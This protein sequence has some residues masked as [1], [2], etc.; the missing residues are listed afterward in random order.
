MKTIQ[1]NKWVFAG[2]LALL[3]MMTQVVSGNPYY[4]TDGDSNPRL[5]SIVSWSLDPDTLDA[6]PASPG[7]G[8]DLIFNRNPLNTE[9]LYAHMGGTDRHYNSFTFRS[10]GTTDILRSAIGN[11]SATSDSLLIVGSGG[12]ILE[13]GAGTVNFGGTGQRVFMRADGS[14]SIVNNSSSDLTFHWQYRPHTTVPAD[15]TTTITVGGTGSGG[16]TFSRVIDNTDRPLALTI[17]NTG[18]GVTTLGETGADFPHNYTGATIVQSGRLRIDGTV[19]ESDV[20]VQNGGLIL[21]N[22]TIDNDLH[23]DAG[24]GIWFDP[25]LTLNVGGTVTFGGFGIANILGADWDNLDLDTPYKLIEGI[26]NTANLSNLGVTEA[27][28]VG[29]EGRQAYF[30]ADSLSMVV[31]P[32]PTTLALVSLTIGAG[33]IL[34]RRFNA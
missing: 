11:P 6:V 10:S 28:S 19:S 21:G 1:R 24:G 3:L 33:L 18:T 4:Y 9:S 25:T 15:T 32:E 17:N 14:Q 26:V 22:G 5:N 8:T 7:S 12:I 23:F 20:T 27:V 29:A 13:A 31:I 16:V 2:T 34:R 30:V